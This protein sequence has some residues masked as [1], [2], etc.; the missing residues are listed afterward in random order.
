MGVSNHLG[1][2]FAIRIPNGKYTVGCL[3]G[4]MEA[5]LSLT[6]GGTWIVAYKHDTKLWIFS[7]SNNFSF[8]F[9][10][11]AE[12]NSGWSVAANSPKNSNAMQL[13]SRYFGFFNNSTNYSVN[14]VLT[15]VQKSS[16]PVLMKYPRYSKINDNRVLSLLHS[17]T[18][19]VR[20]NLKNNYVVGARE[21]STRKICVGYKF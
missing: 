11:A 12:I 10:L 5:V 19:G 15:S 13:L 18:T 1:E 2:T 7:S 14:N 16:I 21:P 17:E 6:V 20:R 3:A 4:Y 8:Y 9:T